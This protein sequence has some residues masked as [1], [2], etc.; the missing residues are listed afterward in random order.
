MKR[1]VGP[2]AHLESTARSKQFIALAGLNAFC[3]LLSPYILIHKVVRTIKKKSR[4]EL[5][6]KR[7]FWK[8]LHHDE[9][10]APQ[11]GPRVVLVGPTMGE[12]KLMEAV[13]KPLEKL[14]P[15]LNIIW[16]IRD[17]G[18]I[19]TVRRSNPGRAIVLWP[20][21]NPLPL[22]KWAKHVR[23][24]VV[25]IVEKFWIPNLLSVAKLSGARIGVINA[26]SNP[27]DRLSSKIKTKYYRWV[28]GNIDLLCF[29]SG[30]FLETTK[31][32]LRQ[33]TRKLVTGNMK[34]DVELP[35]LDATRLN[36]IKKWLAPGS[37]LPFVAAGSTQPGDEDFV[38]EAF[39]K[40]RSGTACRL[41]LAPR[42]P[43]RVNA[44]AEALVAAGFVVSRRSQ[45]LSTPADVYLLDSLGELASVYQFAKA[46]FIGG[47]L[48]GTG[49]NLME[50]VAWGTPVSYGPLRGQFEEL[51]MICES[52]GVG[53]RCSTSDDL[54]SHWS[55]VL[56]DEI[57]LESVRENSERLFA[58]ER[59]STAAT[60]EALLTFLPQSTTRVEPVRKVSFAGSCKIAKPLRKT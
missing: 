24:D 13:T 23:P 33:N 27:K 25:I 50:P 35:V 15:D 26:R 17:Q 47:T 28:A 31:G 11:T 41:I 51:Q 16:C 38:V 32:F 55:R 49:H 48:R 18:T 21:D 4:H 7:W 40:L 1:G 5:D 36:G 42:K 57:F 43:E 8:P 12:V 37:D 2:A 59:G 45:P 14:R 52:F 53:F 39:S 20:F 58:H 3:L 46:S 22:A 44:V 30:Q 9:T 60:I 10:L 6:L 34:L 19:E 54:A 29:Q 56:K